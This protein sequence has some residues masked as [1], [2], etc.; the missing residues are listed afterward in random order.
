[1]TQILILLPRLNPWHPQLNSSCLPS[2]P[3]IFLSAQGLHNKKWFYLSSFFQEIIYLL[4]LLSFCCHF[5]FPVMFLVR[6]SWVIYFLPSYS[7]LFTFTDNHNDQISLL[8]SIKSE[9]LPAVNFIKILRAAFS[10]ISFCQKNTN[11]SRKYKKA[12]QKTFVGKRCS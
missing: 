3:R 2:F 8:P 10:P 4:T 1:M 7:V 6:I 5:H 11:P 12:A 9:F